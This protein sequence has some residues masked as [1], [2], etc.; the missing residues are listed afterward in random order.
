MANYRERERSIVTSLVVDFILLLPDVIAAVLAN[1]LV[2]M[3]DV[4]K[5]INELLATFLS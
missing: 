2:M 3:A 4:L 5:C 1:S